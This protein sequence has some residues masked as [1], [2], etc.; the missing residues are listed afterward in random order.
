MKDLFKSI[1]EFNT[2]MQ[3]SENKSFGALPS[4]AESEL[5]VSMLAE[6]LKEYSEAMKDHNAVEVA[7]GLTDILYLVV[8]AMRRHGLSDSKAMELFN[9]VHASNMSKVC[10]TEQ[11]A[12]N[13]VMYY[14][15]CGVNSS[16]HQTLCGWV[17]KRTDGKVLKPESYFKPDIERILND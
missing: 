15:T 8:G 12:A 16:A 5:S 3:I 14:R 10:K 7:D 2:A 4:P 11:E 6:E 17:V 1:A 9:E 13:T